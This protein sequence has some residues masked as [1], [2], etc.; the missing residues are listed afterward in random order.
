L[1]PVCR[2]AGRQATNQEFA[3]SERF[4][5]FVEEHY[6]AAYR[7]ALSLC[8]HEAD[9][10][11]LTQQVFYIAQHKFHQVRDASKQKSWLFTILSREFVR[12]RRQRARY[13]HHSLELVEAELP[14]I[15]VDHASK[16]DSHG[17]L[18]TLLG[19]DEHFRVPL[20]LFYFDQLSYKE[21]AEVLEVPIGTV[22]SRLA[23][24]KELLRQ[25]LDRPPH[26][27]EN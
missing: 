23:R 21:I 18:A 17:L 12:G 26:H 22:M 8:R 27:T 11:D 19:L 10:C 14:L 24:G 5:K 25:S 7:F 20:G 4:E 6:Q 13:E 16:I 15:T 1:A 2:T 3:M 9:A